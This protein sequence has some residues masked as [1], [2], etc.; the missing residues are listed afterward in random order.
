MSQYKGHLCTWNTISPTG[1][2]FY[3]FLHAHQ[4]EEIDLTYQGWPQ[5][6]PIKWTFYV[7]VP[8]G[9]I[10]YR[11][12]TKRHFILIGCWD[13]ISCST[14]EHVDWW[15][16][17]MFT[18]IQGPHLTV[19]LLSTLLVSMFIMFQI[20]S[21]WRIWWSLINS[22]FSFGYYLFQKKNLSHEICQD[23]LHP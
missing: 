23:T 12:P 15:S 21:V 6:N 8:P 10:I 2:A 3:T 7:T 1:I 5:F 22:K 4:L 19:D 9:E 11:F 17:L 18:L 13:Y 14:L 20:W 16:I